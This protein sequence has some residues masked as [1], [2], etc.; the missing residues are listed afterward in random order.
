M[1]FSDA[2][3]A[4]KMREALDFAG[5]AEYIGKLPDGV[6]TFC[7]KNSIKRRDFSGA[8]SRSLTIAQSCR[9]CA[10]WYHDE[11]IPPWTRCPKAAFPKICALRE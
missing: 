1:A 3:V 6:D 11:R 9:R 10:A 7:T 8:N 5:I 4:D 2:A